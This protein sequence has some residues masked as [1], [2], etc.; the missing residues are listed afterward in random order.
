M[1][2]HFGHYHGIKEMRGKGET[3][4]GISLHHSGQ[5]TLGGEVHIHD[6]LSP[7][8]QGVEIPSPRRADIEDYPRFAYQF[9]D[10]ASRFVFPNVVPPKIETFH[11]TAPHIP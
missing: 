2:Q 9:G 6:L 4:T 1:L 5:M 10:Q 3:P 7:L 8:G 11:S